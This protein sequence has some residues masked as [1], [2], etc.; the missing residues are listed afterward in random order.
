[1]AFLHPCGNRQSFCDP[2][3]A[4][5]SATSPQRCAQLQR[6]I[7]SL[8]KSRRN[9]CR[10]FTRPIPIPAM[11]I[12]SDDQIEPIVP[13]IRMTLPQDLPASRDRWLMSNSNII[14]LR[15]WFEETPTFG[16]QPRH[17][18]ASTRETLELLKAFSR[19]KIR[20][21]A[22]SSSGRCVRPFLRSRCL[23]WSNQIRT[24]GFSK[25]VNSFGSR[26]TPNEAKKQGLTY[27]VCAN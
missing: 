5:Q 14:Y 9:H 7:R 24:F 2:V 15:K 6:L 20:L 27:S 1:M 3:Q 8:P 10:V 17:Y 21:S 12:V 4:G 26:S 16:E 25:P 11:L 22:V 18:C 23:R 19:L 13:I